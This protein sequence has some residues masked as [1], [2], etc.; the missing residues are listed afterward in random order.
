MKRWFQAMGYR[1][2]AM[3][4][5]GGLCAAQGLDDQPVEK[6]GGKENKASPSLPTL[7]VIGDS[8]VKV[9]TPGQRGWG[10]ELGPLFDPKKI[11]VVNRAIGGRSSRTFYTEGR[12]HEVA[13][14][15][16]EGDVVIMQFGH[17]D[18]SPINEDPPVNASTRARGTLRSNGEETVDIVN[19]L[20]GKPETVHS[21]GW[22]LRQF[23]EGARAKGAR[24]IICSP[25]PRKSWNVD[26]KVNRTR[27]GWSLWA[28]QA[29]E[30]SGADFIDLNEIIARI[31]EEM[32][33]AAVEPMFADR[34]THTS[35]EGAALNARAVISGV[36]ALTPNPL[37]FA[38]ST[39]GEDVAAFER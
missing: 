34:G 29:A 30:A 31:Y 37:A 13:E 19:I 6:D 4:V 38:L 25:I 10:E 36:K 33:K 23:A 11:N 18:A 3:L 39:K 17:N 5:G 14:Q 7:W 15:L 21:Y 32:G 16:R 26:G 27:E 1:V 9:G 22:Y 35:P 24:A 28:Q 2:L 20:T 8:T 12:W